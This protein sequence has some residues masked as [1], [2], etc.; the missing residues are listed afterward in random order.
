MRQKWRG[1]SGFALRE[2]VMVLLDWL[3]VAGD[4]NGEGTGAH[5][6]ERSLH[7]TR[8]KPYCCQL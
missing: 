1:T 3:P 5:R 8:A 6:S 2:R 4:F 7:Y